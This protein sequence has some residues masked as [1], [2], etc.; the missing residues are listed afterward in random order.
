MLLYIFLIL[1]TEEPGK[2]YEEELFNLAGGWDRSKTMPFFIKKRYACIP[3]SICMKHFIIFAVNFLF[4][5]KDYNEK[6]KDKGVTVIR[7]GG[8]R[9]SG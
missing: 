3:L 9:C 6:N 5:I 8:E 4:F 2:Y 7:S 1:I